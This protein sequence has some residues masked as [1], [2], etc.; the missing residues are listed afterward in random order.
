ME[1]AAAEIIAQEWKALWSIAEGTKALVAIANP[2]VRPVS[3]TV[4][5]HIALRFMT[6]KI[7]LTGDGEDLAPSCTNLRWKEHAALLILFV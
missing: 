2:L 7:F 5:G 1:V 6:T 4:Y 3:L